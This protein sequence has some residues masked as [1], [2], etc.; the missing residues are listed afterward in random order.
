MGSISWLCLPADTETNQRGTSRDM[1]VLLCFE[2][3]FFLG[4]FSDA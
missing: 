3:V 1:L 2:L 4:H